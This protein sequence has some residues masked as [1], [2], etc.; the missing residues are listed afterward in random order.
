MSTLNQPGAEGPSAPQERLSLT[1][2]HKQ[3]LLGIAR[4]TIERTASGLSLPS[5]DEGTLAE[6]LKHRQSCF[7]TLFKAHDL[8]GCIGNI[9][10]REPLYRAVIESAEGAATRDPRFPPVSRAELPELVIEISVLTELQP[11]PR[12]AERDLLESIVPGRHGV[13]LK[14]NDRLSTF[15]PQVWEHLPE[16]RTFLEKLSVKAGFGPDGWKHPDAALYIYQT[17]NFTDQDDGGVA[18]NPKLEST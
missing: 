15:L 8:R 4:E 2:E 17:E 12:V 9:L 1:S 3:F 14:L 7:V 5:F 11:L 13:V 6:R 10:A 18:T 16:K